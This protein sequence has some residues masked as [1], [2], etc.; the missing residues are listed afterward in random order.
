MTNLQRFWSKV[1][2]VTDPGT[3]NCC[4]LW[5]G[6]SPRGYGTFRVGAKTYRAHRYAYIREVGPIPPG[7]VVRATCYESRCVRPSHLVAAPPTLSPRRAP[8]E[9]PRGEAHT[10]AVLCEADVRTIRAR[11]AA[12]VAQTVLAHTFGVT[13]PTVSYIVRRRVWKHI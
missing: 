2:K 1:D 10:Q 13:Q 11:Y 12:D 5:L 9:R 4:W 7:W 6:V 3:P 8:T